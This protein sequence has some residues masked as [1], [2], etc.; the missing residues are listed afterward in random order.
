MFYD[1]NNRLYAHETHTN[2]GIEITAAT[3]LLDIRR[4][5][6]VVAIYK[7]PTQYIFKFYHCC[8]S[9]KNKNKV[10]TFIFSFF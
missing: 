6:H 3:F 2:N 10:A 5:I 8:A 4:A 9:D 7:P 1:K